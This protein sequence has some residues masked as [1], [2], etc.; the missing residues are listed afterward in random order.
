MVDIGRHSPDATRTKS[1]ARVVNT[2]VILRRGT[3]PT[4][5]SSEL[6]C[7]NIQR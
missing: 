3:Q 6:G 2:V 1:S 7:E 5:A 4:V